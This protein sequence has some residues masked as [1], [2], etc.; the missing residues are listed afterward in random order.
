MA[1]ASPVYADLGPALPQRWVVAA[2]AREIALLA[3][4]AAEFAGTGPTADL[5]LALRQFDAMRAVLGA[6]PEA[7]RADA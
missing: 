5:A 7:G 4:R 1:A 3:A 6:G 2:K